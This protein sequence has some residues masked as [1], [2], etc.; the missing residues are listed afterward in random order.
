MKRR[1]GTIGTA[2]F[3]LCLLALVAV[4]VFPF[5]WMSFGSLKA[6]TQLMQ[7]PPDW[8]GPLTLLNYRKVFGQTDFLFRTLNSF[9]IAL[10][11]VLL[12]LVLGLP[13]AHSIARYR[14]QSLGFVILMVRMIPGISFL[15][16]WFIVYRTVGLLDTY[17][18][19][20]ASHLV[21]TLPL[22]IWIMIGFFEDLPSEIE[23]AAIIDG[24]TK[25]QSFV[26]VALPL[27]RPGIATAAIL[28]FIFSW[29]HFLFALVLGGIRTNP[30]PVT[31]F[32]FINYEE[33]DFGG[34]YAA[35]TLITAPI[36]V[37][38]L[39]IQRQFVEGLTLGG[40]KG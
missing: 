5:A 33:I 36:I 3:Y 39:T 8:T 40:L 17:Q 29:N 23:E 14:R 32:Q 30:L 26:L 2:L 28:S 16:P 31:V 6:G 38:V 22:V 24:C 37:L 35:A 11:A 1:T 25:W 15:L 13:A 20:I 19:I 9:T 10:S 7:I 34:I 18:G 21:L 27:C 12:G 4:I